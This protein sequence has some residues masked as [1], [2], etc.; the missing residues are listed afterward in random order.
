SC[1]IDIPLTCTN[2]TPIHNSC[3]FESPGGIFLQT[4]FWDY[5]P[6]IGDNDSF[7]LHG[8]WPDNCD[9]SYE[10]FCDDELNLK[11]HEIKSIVVDQFKDN[12]LYSKM[13]HNW[14]NF[15][16]DDE[17][18]WIHEF[19]KHGTCIK[20]LRPTC[21]Y[22]YVKN[23]NIYDFYKIS[24][25]IYE[26][27]PTFKFL[28]QAGITPS[29]TKTY[30]KQ[31]IS[32]ALSSQ[33][34]GLQVYFKCNRYQVLQEI[35]YYHY[36]KGSIKQEDFVPIP[37]L[38]NSNC[39]QE[40][41]KFLPKGWT[42]PNGPP[43]PNPNP[44]RPKPPIG[45]DRGYLK[46]PN[47]AGCIISN[48]QWYQYGTCATFTVSKSQFGGYNLKSSKGYCGFDKQGQLSCG[49]FYQPAKY[50]FAYDKESGEISYGGLS[51]WCFNK[52]N[53]HGHGKF[54]QIPIKL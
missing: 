34:E 2:S 42:P 50:Q 49:S 38:L 52:E 1:P 35:W 19:N 8:L 3:C 18:L 14:K 30:T 25:N 10:Q 11:P 43:S 40:G 54:Q 9:G 41:I 37:S 21:Y 47:H 29:E 44:G 32:D 22:P 39:P 45:G 12:E 53:S 33:F 5:Y 31:E 16:G 4:Q 36:L 13:I 48:G 24:M 15:N 17:N 27:L 6:P 26:K 20:T 46:L 51:K 23:Q 7:T 28:E